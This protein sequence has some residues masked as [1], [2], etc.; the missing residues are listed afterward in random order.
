[1][2]KLV[3]V[4]VSLWLCVSSD[5]AKV[6]KKKEILKLTK[7]LSMV[8]KRRQ[9]VPK[10]RRA[11]PGAPP[12]EDN[13][14]MANNTCPADR[15][16]CKQFT[17]R[18]EEMD[19]DCPGTCESCDGCR[20]QDNPQ[21]HKYCPYW[22]Q[23]CL[24]PGTL[25]TWMTANCRKT[26]GK[27]RCK[28]CSYK[29]KQHGLGA[30]ILLPEKC[31][32]LV[33]EQGL[34]AGSSPLLPGAATHSISHPDELTLNF[35][36]LHNGA[37]CCVLPGDARL[38]NGSTVAG[39]SMVEEG[40]NGLLQR[41]GLTIPTTCC[42]GTL[43]VPLTV[44][45]TITS[46][47]TTPKF[48]TLPHCKIESLSF[49]LDISGSMSGGTMN[50][51]KPAATKL[52]DEM[53]R[54]LVNIDRH[55][56]FTYVDRIK[57]ST[58]TNNTED[59]KN[60]IN[61]W[62]SFSGSRELTFA[63]LKHAM[64]KVNTNAFVCVWTDEIGDDTTDINLKNDILNLKAATNSE[65]FIMAVTAQVSVTTSGKKVRNVEE[66]NEDDDS[67]K[68]RASLTLTQFEQKFNGIGHVMDI[69]N[70]NNAINKIIN[71]MTQTAICNQ[72]ITTPM[73]A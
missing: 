70:D 9:W 21:W 16:H 39:G 2:V 11:G 19:R 43:S 53:A 56:L 38:G 31:G 30:R 23:Y 29:G 4:L 36:S 22:T 10:I 32:E 69:T 18:G 68:T 48:E 28:C 17:E 33:C 67:G 26:C 55:Y 15:G 1:M 57:S 7:S 54:R 6:C 40:W 12:C 49:A 61:N 72:G 3:V 37:D 71:I 58:T 50:I 35:R 51:W 62:N 5:F 14:S 63:A 34:V 42:H 60:T 24:N 52:V 45:S 65:I 25:G 47:T 8:C 41:N 66:K 44:V 59:F 20:C 64:E 13:P 46:G 27:C 73:V